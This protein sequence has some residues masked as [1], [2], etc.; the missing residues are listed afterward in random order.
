[1]CGGSSIELQQPAESKEPVTESEEEDEDEEEELGGTGVDEH[2][3]EAVAAEEEAGMQVVLM[4]AGASE[5]VD[6]AP[7]VPMEVLESSVAGSRAAKADRL[8]GR[9]SFDRDTWWDD[10]G[11]R[12]QPTGRGSTGRTACTLGMARGTESGV[13]GKQQAKGVGKA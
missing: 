9:A 12:R 8:E 10:G 1:M 3:D 5:S 11:V 2:Y 4:E 7:S 13:E 6:L